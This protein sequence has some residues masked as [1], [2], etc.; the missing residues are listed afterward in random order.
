MRAVCLLMLSL[1]FGACGPAEAGPRGAEGA[2][3]LVV[4]ADPELRAL[5][6]ELLPELS[7]RSGLALETPVRL[8]RRSRS[9]LETY[10]RVKLDEE[11]PP[12]RA[13]ALGRAYHLLGL[14]PGDLALRDLLLSVYLE[15]VAGFYDPDSTALFV[16]DDQ[17]PDQLRPLLLHELVHAVQD[18]SADLDALTAP[19]LG[20]DRRKAAQAAIEGHATLVMMEHAL[21]EMQ[22][23]DLDLSTIPDMADRLRPALESVQAQFPALA[24]APA[25]VQESLLYPYL[26]GAGFVLALWR[27]GAERGAAFRGALPTSTEQVETPAKLLGPDV[28]VPTLLTI[29]PARGSVLLSDDLGQA[30][31]ELLLRERSGPGAGDAAVGWDGDRYAL[32]DPG[33]GS[34]P[35]LAWASVWDDVRARDR[36][37]AAFRPG[38]DDLPAAAVLEPM[39]FDGRPGALLR[40]GLDVEV[41]VAVEGGAP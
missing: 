24:S 18:Q 19:E 12:E 3:T 37:V 7:L 38:L 29:R 41:A 4:T 5:A 33:D 20:N 1:G 36:F 27:S 31:V 8:E 28:D 34:P 6:A 35:G 40:V 30:E 23:A 26:E 13:R 11:L 25:V 39:E 2:D 9:E 10:L 32:I 15:Q 17:G 14:A 21:G 22:G 16:L